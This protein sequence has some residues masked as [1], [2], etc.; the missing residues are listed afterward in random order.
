MLKWVSRNYLRGT[1]RAY[2][3]FLCENY[4]FELKAFPKVVVVQPPPPVE[5]KVKPKSHSGEFKLPPDL[6]LNFEPGKN[7]ARKAQ[8]IASR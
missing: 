5:E 2:L 6:M 3:E 1:K 8:S 7:F 4:A